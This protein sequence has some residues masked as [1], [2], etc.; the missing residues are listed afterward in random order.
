[1]RILGLAAMWTTVFTLWAWLWTRSPCSRS[2]YPRQPVFLRGRRRRAGDVLCHVIM[3]VQGPSL[4]IVLRDFGRELASPLLGVLSVCM[5]L[6][7]ICR[8]GRC[9]R[10]GQGSPVF[11]VCLE[12][13]R[14]VQ[15]V[16]RWSSLLKLSHMTPL[17]RAERTIKGTLPSRDSQSP[18]NE[19]AWLP[20]CD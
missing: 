15:G 18:Y 2:E 7:A 3:I 8:L 1:M 4:P 20:R 16:V 19:A 14:G 12:V 9:V 5:H 17:C 6:G 13:A 11:L 10:E